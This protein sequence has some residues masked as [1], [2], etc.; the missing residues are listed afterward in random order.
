[1][2]TAQRDSLRLLRAILVASVVLPLAL[3]S[4]ATWLAHRA[5]EANAELQI[6]KTRDIITEHALKIFESVQRSIAETGEII[7][8]M[9]DD[10]IRANE[11]VLHARLKRLVSGSEQIKSMWIF[12]RNGR[13]LVNTLIYPSPETDFSDRDYFKVPMAS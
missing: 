6:D 5:N 1:M 13:T 10:A 7:R 3:F 12:D 8:D 9:P 4:Y 11:N 2:L